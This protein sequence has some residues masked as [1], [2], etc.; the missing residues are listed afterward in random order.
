MGSFLNGTGRDTGTGNGPRNTVSTLF[1]DSVG[2]L[3]EERLHFP[4]IVLRGGFHVR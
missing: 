2:G 4:P 1:A 3:R